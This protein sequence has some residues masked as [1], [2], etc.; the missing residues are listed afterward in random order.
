MFCCQMLGPRAVW[1]RGCWLDRLPGMMTSAAVAA[2]AAAAP[3]M[4]GSSTW[5]VTRVT[6][7]LANYNV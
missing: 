4:S 6:L 7:F 5:K 3:N 1:G 2:G